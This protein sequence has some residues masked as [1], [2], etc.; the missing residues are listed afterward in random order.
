MAVHA[1]VKP[2]VGVGSGGVGEE[3]GLDGGGQKGGGWVSACSVN[4]SWVR[5]LLLLLLPG[6]VDILGLHVGLIRVLPSFYLLLLL[7][8]LLLLLCC[9]ARDDKACITCVWGR[10]GARRQR[11]WNSLLLL[12]LLLLCTS[13]PPLPCSCTAECPLQLCRPA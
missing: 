13:P 6:L 5:R 1:L 3:G 4:T 2:G 9:R 10:V 7:P 11:Q 8:P 12:L